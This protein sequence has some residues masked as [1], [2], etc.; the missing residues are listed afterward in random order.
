MSFYLEVISV[1]DQFIKSYFNVAW[2]MLVT[3][4]V[5]CIFYLA[6]YG[7]YRSSLFQISYYGIYLSNWFVCMEAIYNIVLRIFNRYIFPSKYKDRFFNQ[8][9]HGFYF[10]F[11][12]SYIYFTLCVVVS[13]SMGTLFDYGQW[14]YL[15]V[16]LFYSI[17]GVILVDRGYILIKSIFAR[18][19]YSNKWSSAVYLLLQIMEFWSTLFQMI[20]ILIRLLLMISMG[21]VMFGLIMVFCQWV[22][23]MCF[24]LICKT[25]LGAMYYGLLVAPILGFLF[26]MMLVETCFVM[27]YLN[28]SIYLI[29]LYVHGLIR[30]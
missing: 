5:V 19:P 10:S 25:I 30:G 26:G 9:I 15:F 17:W 1:Y 29:F 2:G 16:Y 18:L 28:I 21:Q 3:L 22:Q 7:M 13:L 24:N 27:I 12:F 6:T 20:Y 11:I 14:I 8:N 4:I 23:F